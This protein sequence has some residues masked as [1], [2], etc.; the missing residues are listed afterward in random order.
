MPR[1]CEALA[2]NGLDASLLTLEEVGTPNASYIS[3]FSPS[4]E[5]IG[6][7]KRL[8]YSSRLREG[9]QTHAKTGR[10]IHSHGFWMMPNA[11]AGE[12]AKRHD[13]PLVVTPRGMLTEQ[14]LAFSPLKKKL[15][16]EFVQKSAYSHTSLWHATSEEEADYIRKFGLAGPIAII[17]NG[18]DL[19]DI[20]TSESGSAGS[21]TVLF[22]SRLHP[23][24]GLE[25]L[26]E[27]WAI[28]ASHFPDW[29]LRVVGPDE[30]KYRDK[31]LSQSRSLGLE[32]IC[33]PGPVYGVAKE[34]LIQDAEILIL[35]TRSEN[36]GI[37]IAEALA[38][39][40][41]V[42][43][44]K[45]APWEGV[46]EH[47]CGWWIDHGVEAISAA[48][49]SAM[50]LS[51][52]D[53]KQMGRRGR[54]WMLRAYSWGNVAEKMAEAYHWLLFGGDAPNHVHK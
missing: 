2:E 13:V 20:R 34:K 15:F 47:S 51:Y 32:R 3:A 14:A 12:M 37:V 49:T 38:A 16:W 22:L 43:V 54:E 46:V 8:G 44:S 36:F 9:I 42:I 39:E 48:L 5:G 40:T 17:P 10:I 53:R 33:F 50:S 25:D 35:P 27:A 4:L 18:V 6:F 26:I 24:K 45:G 31:L 41:P 30:D 29:E 28:V 21:K 19:P 52:E 11:Y 7:L 1:L 23:K